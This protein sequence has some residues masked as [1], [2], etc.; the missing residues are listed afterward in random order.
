M[1]R[2][3]SCNVR[4]SGARNCGPA[5]LSPLY[6]AVTSLIHSHQQLIGENHYLSHSV[7]VCL[8]GCLCV[9]LCL[10]VFL[11]TRLPVRPSVCLSVYVYVSVR[12][13]DC[14]SVSLPVLPSVCLQ[15]IFLSVRPSVRQSAHPLNFLFLITRNNEAV[16]LTY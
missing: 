8:H 14:L 12:L 7:N 1:H 10:P 2:R 16:G 3:L 4:R 6:S 9:S 5:L 13:P 15:S 11:S